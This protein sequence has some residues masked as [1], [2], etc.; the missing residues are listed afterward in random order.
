MQNGP[1]ISRIAA[2]IGDGA[3]ANILVALMGGRAL[4][5]T[6]LAAVAGVTAQTASSHLAKLT[7]GGLTVVRQQGRHRYFALSDAE[8][9]EL[10]GALMG[11]AARSAAPAIRVG[12]RD[13]AMR[14]ARVCYDHLAGDLAVQLFDSLVA[15]GAL[16]TSAGLWLTADGAARMEQLGVDVA[17]LRRARAP[18]VRECLD[19]SERRSHLGGALGRALYARMLALGWARR[20]EGTRVVRFT[21]DGERRLREILPV[22][23]AA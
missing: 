10:V 17:A 7:D 11:V 9:A 23:L 21:P 22:P 12:P 19:W 13:A 6:E 15:A 2:L 4:T 14:R 1:D 5:A 16:D 3:R 18:L 20:E 8:V